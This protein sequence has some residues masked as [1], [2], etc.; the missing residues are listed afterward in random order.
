METAEGMYIFFGIVSM[1][2]AIIE[3]VKKTDGICYHGWLKA[4][5]WGISGISD[6][7]FAELYKGDGCNVVGLRLFATVVAMTLTAIAI[8]ISSFRIK[9]DGDGVEMRSV[10]NR[11]RIDLNAD[12]LEIKRDVDFISISSGKKRIKLRRSMRGFDGF[13]EKLFEG[14]G[15]AEFLAA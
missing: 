11:K 3:F 4:C 15:K 2:T 12:G 13:C 6:L 5:Y 8:Y 1:V 14:A 7:S 9:L 10:L